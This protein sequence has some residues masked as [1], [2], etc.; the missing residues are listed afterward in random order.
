MK[1]IKIQ[2]EFYIIDDSEPI[3]DELVIIDGGLGRIG[4][5]KYYTNVKYSVTPKKIIHSTQDLKGVIKLNKA[6]ILELIGEFDVYNLADEQ[7]DKDTNEIP[8]PTPLWYDSQNVQFN[9]FI[10]GFNKH[11]ELTKD[12]LYTKKD[13]VNGMDKVYGWMIPESGNGTFLIDGKFYRPLVLDDVK[14]KFIQSLQP[15]TEWDI[16]I[17][18]DKIT[19]L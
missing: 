7:F 16:I 11:K 8:L 17:E 14:D 12:K 3:L 19:L 15:K 6:E 4:V 9:S 13:L 10:K 5:G 18:N 1:L 2:E